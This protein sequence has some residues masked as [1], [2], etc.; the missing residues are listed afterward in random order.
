MRAAVL[1]WVLAAAGCYLGTAAST[2]GGDGGTVEGGGG[3]P[4]PVGATNL[5]C[6]VNLVLDQNGCRTCHYPGGDGP[7][8]LYT[9][10]DLTSPGLSDPTRSAAEMSVSRMSDPQGPMPPPPASPASAADIATLEAWIAAGY[11]QGDCTAAIDP[12]TAAPTCT[13]GAFTRGEEELGDRMHPGGACN[14]CHQQRGEGIQ[15]T[16]AGTIYPTGHEPGDCN[17]AGS[18]GATV[19]VTGA[20]GQVIVLGLNAVGT[21][22]SIAPVALPFT[23]KVKYQGRERV[24]SQPQTSGDCNF[25]HTQNGASGAPGRITLP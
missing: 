5:P 3:N 17:G 22:T 24:M 11:P 25:C 18:S 15:Y 10:T 12:L 14:A 7:I 4:P 2:A 23:A 6:D 19:E 9:W 1:A 13:S 8:P 21:F 16:I 20:T